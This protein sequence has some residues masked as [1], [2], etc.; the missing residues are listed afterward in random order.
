MRQ[1]GLEL[2]IALLL[3]LVAGVFWGTWFS[4]SRSMHVLSPDIFITIGKQIMENV[5]ATMRII[6]PASV[7]GLVV[8]LIGSWKK[9]TVYFYCIFIALILFVIAL[10][11]TLAI[12]VP[13]DNEIRTWTIATVPAN[14]EDIRDRWEKYHMV[15]TF[16]SLGSVTFFTIAILN[17]KKTI[18]GLGSKN[19]HL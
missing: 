9:K 8:L 5:A 6:M 19:H 7:I 2:I 4:L 16:L 10:L 13:I 17:K 14:W 1:K 3:T 15:R 11:I 12:E 18:Y